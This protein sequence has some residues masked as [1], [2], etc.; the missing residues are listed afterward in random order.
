MTQND[1]IRMIAA[2]D[3]SDE[4]DAPF[5]EPDE[6]ARA[7]LDNL[8]TMA[9]AGLR[10]LPGL[11][12]APYREFGIPDPALETHEPPDV[13][14][15][16][17]ATGYRGSDITVYWRALT[18]NTRGLRSSFTGAELDALIT[19]AQAADLEPYPG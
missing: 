5:S 12:W 18:K 17:C 15:R 11:R 8:I 6:D 9:R 3:L 19:T 7:V 16:I 4:P 2:M 14:V 13:P 10:R 1:F